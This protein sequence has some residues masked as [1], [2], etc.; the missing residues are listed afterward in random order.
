MNSKTCRCTMATIVV[1]LLGSV[2]VLAL[3]INADER[4]EVTRLAELTRWKEGTV[5]ADF[6]AAVSMGRRNTS[7]KSTC[8]G[9]SS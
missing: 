3:E 9:L 2:G 6:N 8:K 4:Q 1:T 5:V 7:S